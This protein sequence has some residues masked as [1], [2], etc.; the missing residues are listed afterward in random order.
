MNFLRTVIGA[1][2][3]FRFYRIALEWSASEPF[4]HLVKLSAV[5]AAVC[6][7]ILAPRAFRWTAEATQWI[8]RELKL[9][10]FTIESGK[11]RSD[12]PQPAVRRA[13]DFLFILDTTGAT[14]LATTG[15]VNGIIVTADRV[16]VW[17]GRE[18]Q[19]QVLP[20]SQ[21]PQGRVDAAYF[22]ELMTMLIW[23]L[24]LPALGMFFGLFLTI[25]LVQCAAFSGL[26]SLLERPI[27]PRFTFAQLFRLTT[28]A[29]TPASVVAA[30]YGAL[31][32]AQ[33]F[34]PM[35]YLVVFGFYFS[36]AAAV[37]RAALIRE[38]GGIK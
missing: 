24:V 3:G 12:A 16:F 21:L 38:G 9:P 17:A 32:W 34:V 36:G 5:L 29:V 31:G 28:L 26:A 22:R 13:D 10:A 35:V 23:L 37:C 25:G 27:T 15:A 11:V 14:P 8:E 18:A 6:V 2:A 19:P 4:K 30:A 20:V 33:G 1:C 7:L